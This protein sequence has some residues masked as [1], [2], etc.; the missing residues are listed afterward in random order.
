[1]IRIFFLIILLV[2]LFLSSCTWDNNL[3]IKPVDNKTVTDTAINIDDDKIIIDPKKLYQE[4]QY[5]KALM[6]MLE[7]DPMLLE[8][9]SAR[10]LL[11]SINDRLVTVQWYLQKSIIELL[12]GHKDLALYHIEEALKLYP[13]H[14]PSFLLKQRLDSIRLN[15][16]HKTPKISLKKDKIS[17]GPT[18]KELE[19]A[20]Y[21]LLTGKNFFEEGRLKLAKESWF[22]G[23]DIVPSHE[24]IKENLVKLLTNEGLQL[25]GQGEIESSIK[26][27]EEALKI[28]PDDPKIQDYLDKARKA[29]EKVRSID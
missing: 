1:M 12:K 26:K 20:D 23:L 3:K 4:K 2:V 29:E 5:D 28:K 6:A 21:Y 22:Q 25:F 18:S 27:W 24:V 9:P 7:A 11:W 13:Q 14:K 10:K 15:E 19:L 8:D 17:I 16:N